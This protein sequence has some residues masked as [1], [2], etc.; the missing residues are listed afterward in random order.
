MLM[1]V[2]LYCHSSFIPTTKLASVVYNTLLPS[3]CIKEHNTLNAVKTFVSKEMKKELRNNL[4]GLLKCRSLSGISI[5]VSVKQLHRSKG[6]LKVH[7][8]TILFNVT[9]GF[10]PLLLLI[11]FS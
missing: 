8:L 7:Y 9:N 6:L 2:S 4:L 3:I 11:N 1:E 5:T 10:F